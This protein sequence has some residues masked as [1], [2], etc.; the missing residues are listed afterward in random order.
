MTPRVTPT[1]FG[2]NLV[3]AMKAS[4]ASENRADIGVLTHRLP[5]RPPGSLTPLTFTI[6]LAQ[7][8]DGLVLVTCRELPE[9]IT[10]AE[11]ESEALSLAHLAI[12]ADLSQRPTSVEPERRG[13]GS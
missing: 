13:L 2:L 8:Q 11:D 4:I 9:I 3:H 1:A 7:D 5:I 6:D 12:L 10:A